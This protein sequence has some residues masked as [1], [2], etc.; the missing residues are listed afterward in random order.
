MTHDWPKWSAWRA[1]FVDGS[2]RRVRVCKACGRVD[3]QIASAFMRAVLWLFYG[4]GETL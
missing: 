1:G 4:I 2:V 3:M